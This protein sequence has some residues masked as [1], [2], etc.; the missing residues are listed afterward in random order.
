MV[1]SVPMVIYLYWKDVPAGMLTEAL[2]SGASAVYWLAESDTPLDVS[3]F[4]RASI[5]PTTIT[6]S[7][8]AV[9]TNSSKVT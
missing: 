3:Q 7:P 9:V 6:L 5:E 4:P 2:Q 1:P 8:Q